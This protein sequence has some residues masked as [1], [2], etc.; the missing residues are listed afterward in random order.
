MAATYILLSASRREEWELLGGSNVNR[1]KRLQSISSVN[2]T[3]NK[4]TVQ[5]KQTYTPLGS[6]VPKLELL[7][8]FEALNG[9]GALQ[10]SLEN[11]NNP[12]DKK[13]KVFI[14]KKQK[15]K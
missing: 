14:T 6:I 11:N 2:V 1:N 4:V 12:K 8:K 15:T 10:A 3:F 5:N 13:E 9:G 7:T